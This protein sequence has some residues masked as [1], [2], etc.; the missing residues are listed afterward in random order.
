MA[1]MKRKIPNNA[2]KTR[3]KKTGKTGI[4]RLNT[5]GN[6]CN[7][8]IA[9]MNGGKVI[10]NFTTKFYIILFYDFNALGSFVNV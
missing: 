9:R 6:K 5:F 2:S 3:N 1:L 8:K 10:F 7:G 4:F